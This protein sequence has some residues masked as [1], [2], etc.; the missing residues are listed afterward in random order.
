MGLFLFRHDVDSPHP[1]G[2]LTSMVPYVLT[3]E[4]VSLVV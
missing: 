2:L 1:L 4:M 3:Y